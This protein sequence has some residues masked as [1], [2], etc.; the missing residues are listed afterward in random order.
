MLYSHFECLN[1]YILR[2]FRDKFSIIYIIRKGWVIE[3]IKEKG[4][5]YKLGFYKSKRCGYLFLLPSLLGVIIFVFLPFIDSIKRAF[6]EA[7]SSK[8]VGIKNFEN[9]INNDAFILASKNT[10]KFL[11]TCIPLLLI[12]S[13]LLAFMICNLKKYKEFIKTA[14]LVPMSIPVASV[15]LIWK[16]F[17]HSNGLINKYLSMFGYT[18]NVEY[19]NS[20]KAFYVLVFTY[21]WKNCGYTMILW[22]A[23]LSSINSSIYEAAAVDGCSKFKQFIYIT[24]PNLKITLFTVTTLSIVNS[25]K[26]FR[27]AYLISGDYP[28]ESIYMMQHLFNNWFVSLDVQKMC[29][30]A[31]IMAAFILT[32][33]FILQIIC[34]R[35]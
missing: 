32:I 29:A 23:G 34:E 2:L 25:F 33:I 4:H 13:L 14:Y 31:V 8:F 6:F 30:A 5:L 11:F 16:V 19:L 18:S 28:H 24:L 15:V 17:F 20:S 12:I 35:E 21:I 22:L 26:V 3:M 27:E 7:M 9:V 10:I 1:F